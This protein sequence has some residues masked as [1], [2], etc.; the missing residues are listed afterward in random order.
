MYDAGVGCKG[1]WHLRPTTFNEAVDASG[2]QDLIS[3]VY[4]QIKSVGR[5]ALMHSLWPVFAVGFHV[6]QAQ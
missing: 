5:G 2:K 1:V 6:R 4:L 3:L